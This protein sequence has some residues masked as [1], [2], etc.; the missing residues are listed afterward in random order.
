MSKHAITGFPHPPGRVDHASIAS[1]I[2]YFDILWCS[3]LGYRAIAEPRIDVLR[4]LPPDLV[5]IVRRPVRFLLPDPD[6]ATASKVAS[7]LN[8]A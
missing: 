1:P 6:F 4:K 8:V 2:D 3:D 5:Q 7:A